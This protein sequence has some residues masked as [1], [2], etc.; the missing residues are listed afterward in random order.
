MKNIFKDQNFLAEL[1]VAGMG[2]IYQYQYALKKMET[3]WR[4]LDYLYI[5]VLPF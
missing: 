1:F 5:F 4:P 2:H 3:K